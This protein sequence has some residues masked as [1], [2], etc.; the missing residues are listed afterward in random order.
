MSV[1]KESASGVFEKHK[2]TNV[3]TWA[4][5]GNRLE[6]PSVAVGGEIFRRILETCRTN[7]DYIILDTPP[8]GA[9]ADAEELAESGRCVRFLPCG[10]TAC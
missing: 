3:Y 2:D 7:M 6:E 10:R 8:M 5:A 1:G 9:A 4:S